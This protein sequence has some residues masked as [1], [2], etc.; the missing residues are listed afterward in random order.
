[1]SSR[2]KKKPSYTVIRTYDFLDGMAAETPA[3]RAISATRSFNV[4]SFN[5][6]YGSAWSCQGKSGKGSQH[7]NE[8][9]H[10]GNKQMTFCT[11]VCGIGGYKRNK[12]PCCC[13]QI[14]GNPALYCLFIFS[15]YVHLFQRLRQNLI[16][17]HLCTFLSSVVVTRA[18][19]SW[20]ESMAQQ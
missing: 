19:G 3:T 8:E 9:L 18:H 7:N 1:M 12:C 2:P 4:A 14:R 16:P 10:F 17:C 20:L 15:P 13:Y 6:N 11:I 5:R